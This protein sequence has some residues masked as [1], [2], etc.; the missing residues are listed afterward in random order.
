MPTSLPSSMTNFLVSGAPASRAQQCTPHPPSPTQGLGEPINLD[1]GA[2]NVVVAV[3]VV[4][5]A[6][7]L[8]PWLIDDFA[9]DMEITSV[10]GGDHFH[11]SDVVPLSETSVFSQSGNLVDVVVTWTED[12]Q[13]QTV[14]DIY[15]IC[16]QLV[17]G[18][19]AIG[20][21]SCRTFGPF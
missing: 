4:L 2:G 5:D 12:Q 13:P 3:L 8:R 11:G 10:N 1:F 20:P 21:E 19:T 16:S 14:G 6:S 17:V 15:T 7:F 18:A 9:L